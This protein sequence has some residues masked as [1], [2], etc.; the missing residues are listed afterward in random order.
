VNRASAQ[1]FRRPAEARPLLGVVNAWMGLVL[2]AK[3]EQPPGQ[4]F[5]IAEIDESPGF[6]VR[7]VG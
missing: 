1:E 6:G 4:L 3:R 7:K 5:P 2:V